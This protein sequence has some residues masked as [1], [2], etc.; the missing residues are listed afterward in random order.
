MNTIPIV[1]SHVHLWTAAQLQTLAW[2]NPNNPLGAQHSV[3]EYLSS[4]GEVAQNRGNKTSSKNY[5]LQGFI[6]LEVDRLSSVNEE[7]NDPTNT[8]GWTYVLDEISFLTRIAHG[9][10]LQGEGHE[11]DHKQLLLG[12]VPWAPVPGGPA[13]LEKYVSLAKERITM[14]VSTLSSQSAN[15]NTEADSNSVWRKLRGVRYLVQDKPAGTML[16]PGFVEGLKWLGRQKLAFDLGLDA[17]QG[18][19]SQL[20]EA[21]ELMRRVYD[22]DVPEGDRVVVVISKHLVFPVST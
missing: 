10:P 15:T 6:Y 3:A 9:S 12:F 13:V 22:D 21:V 16:Q 18:G 4:V 8:N 14:T 19:L 17:R 1:D 7:N 5:F 20:Q 2:H 11:K